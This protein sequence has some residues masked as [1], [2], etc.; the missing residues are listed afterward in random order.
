MEINLM[1]VLKIYIWQLDQNMVNSTISGKKNSRAPT[2]LKSLYLKVP[3]SL[4]LR[5]GTIAVPHIVALFALK[6]VQAITVK[7]IE[8]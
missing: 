1:I 3:R 2:A 7:K 6:N 5:A 4:H 8:K